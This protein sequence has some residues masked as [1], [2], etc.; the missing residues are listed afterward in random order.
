M[1]NP[2]TDVIL[3]QC[4]TRLWK[5]WVNKVICPYCGAICECR[6]GEWHCALEK[7]QQPAPDS[8][9]ELDLLRKKVA[10]LEAALPRLVQLAA[11]DAV[12]NFRVFGDGDVPYRPSIYKRGEVWRYHRRVAA[13]EWEDHE[14]PLKAALLANGLEE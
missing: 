5:P 13:N 2:R 11:D 8:T 14:D 9:N 4:G 10:Y 7:N 12:R 1:K 6:D 3:C